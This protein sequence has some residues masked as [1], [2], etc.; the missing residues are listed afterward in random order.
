M[1]PPRRERGQQHSGQRAERAEQRVL[2]EHDP[3]D[4]VARRAERLEQHPFAQPVAARRGDGAEQY[5][6]G[7]PEADEREEAN[8][9]RH[10]AEHALTVRCTS[11]RSRLEM[12][13]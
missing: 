6:H 3:H 8:G 2:G 12:L 5:R 1:Q 10:L 7:E 9:H 13:G 4:L 11:V